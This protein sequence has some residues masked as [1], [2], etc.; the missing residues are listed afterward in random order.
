MSL[1]TETGQAVTLDSLP[2]V[3]LLPPEI[4]ETR[5]FRRIQIGLGGA[6]LGAVGIVALLY[7]AATSSVSSAQSNLD[8]AN[9][10]HT[11]L[12]AETAK[13]R[14]VTAVYARAAAA[15]AMLTQ[16]MGEEVRYSQLMNDL[17]LSV[18]ETVWLKNV[19]FTQTALAAATPGATPGI[20]T[21]TVTGVG[22]SH[23]DVAVWLESLAGQKSYAN[24]YFSG[25]TEALMGTRKTV[26]FSSTAT[27]TPAAYSGR[28]TK[29]AG[30]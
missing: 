9:S 2:R 18:P 19:S 25:S 27:L 24:P 5:R 28:Y 29:P 7:V 14:D 21:L 12:T 22:F 23:D 16:A 8:T 1:M 11:Q 20:G 15:Q 10:T 3:N 26:N 6:V 13:Y 30:G 17:S 4:A